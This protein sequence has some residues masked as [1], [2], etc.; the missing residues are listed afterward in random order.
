VHGQ[1]KWDTLKTYTDRW[2]C[3]TR[4]ESL[5][6]LL[7]LSQPTRARIVRDWIIE[8]MEKERLSREARERV[9]RRFTHVCEFVE[10]KQGK[11]ERVTRIVEISKKNGA[12]FWATLD[13]TSA[14]CSFRRRH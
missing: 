3:G 6:A 2:D 13:G 11:L 7:V 8:E 4:I 10:E 1:G 12:L 14:T 5:W 9:S